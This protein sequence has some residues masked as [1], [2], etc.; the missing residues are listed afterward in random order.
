MVNYSCLSIIIIQFWTSCILQH[1][2]NF[3]VFL[4]LKD[5]VTLTS[6]SVRTGSA[7]RFPGNVISIPIESLFRCSRD[8]NCTSCGAWFFLSAS[9]WSWIFSRF[10]CVKQFICKTLFDL[11]R[12]PLQ[13]WIFQLPFPGLPPDA[14][15]SLNFIQFDIRDRCACTMVSRRDF[16]FYF[17][18]VSS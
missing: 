8:A 7:S 3:C 17:Y 18:G 1:F 11:T 6:S 2:L 13:L 4:Q 16:V 10:N 14:L 9:R 15:G 12:K 5:R